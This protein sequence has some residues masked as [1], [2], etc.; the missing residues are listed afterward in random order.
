MSCVERLKEVKRLSTPHL[1]D[2]NAIRAM[3][4]GGA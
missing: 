2:Q 3:A 1:S 4:Q